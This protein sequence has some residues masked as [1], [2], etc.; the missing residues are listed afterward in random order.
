M[1]TA[2][3]TTE[4]ELLRFLSALRF[5]IARDSEHVQQLMF[6]VPPTRRRRLQRVV[7]APTTT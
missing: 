3:N 7:I 1:A 2:L 5:D 6:A 4:E